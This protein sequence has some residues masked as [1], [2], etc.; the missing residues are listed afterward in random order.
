MS[1]NIREAKLNL[2]R[3]LDLTGVLPSKDVKDLSGFVI[4]TG[5]RQLDNNEIFQLEVE[6]VLTGQSLDGTSRRL[7]KGQT[8]AN[9]TFS[10]SVR[11]FNL[12]HI[13]VSN[14]CGAGVADIEKFHL[15]QVCNIEF[16]PETES[17]KKYVPVIEAAN[18]DA[19]I[20]LKVEPRSRIVEYRVGLDFPWD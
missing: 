7:A 14:Y 10:P 1:F 9:L 16:A 6:G 5:L 4:A 12:A 2:R 17:Y 13:I 11:N 3:G 20:E 18:K 8:S 19:L 15:S